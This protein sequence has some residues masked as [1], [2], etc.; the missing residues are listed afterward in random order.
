MDKAEVPA[1]IYIG[2]PSML[3]MKG[4]SKNPPPTPK[5]ADRMATNSPAI[6]TTMALY[7]NSSPEKVK[8]FLIPVFG[9]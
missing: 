2:N 1:T 9:T 6:N 3:V 5:E 7:V 8:L 4:T